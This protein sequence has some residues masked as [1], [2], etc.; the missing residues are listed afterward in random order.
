V[1]FKTYSSPEETLE[2]VYEGFR[3]ELKA[4]F[5]RFPSVI[6]KDTDDLVQ[7][8]YER[9]LRQPR[10]E[11]ID[12]PKKLIFWLAWQ[13]LR[14]EGPKIRKHVRLSVS[15]DSE[16]LKEV[17]AVQSR[18]WQADNS[19]E[20]VD[21]ADLQRHIEALP[22]K[23]RQVFALQRFE[24]LTVPEISATTGINPH[25]VK[26]YLQQAYRRLRQ[27]YSADAPSIGKAAAKDA[28]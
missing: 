13:V 5:Q 6:S 27:C 24:H 11:E 25:T 19:S 4:F 10:L 1:T 7:L 15:F 23:Q 28:L 17:A 21:H 20:D 14:T 22:P 18:L 12:D 9:L 8:V 2:Q 3:E 26:K 16:E